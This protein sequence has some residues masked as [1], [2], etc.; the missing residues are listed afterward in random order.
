MEIDY[1]DG[2]VE[3]LAALYRKGWEME[4][5]AEAMELPLA[6][7]SQVVHLLGLGD[8]RYKGQYIPSKGSVSVA[9]PASTPCPTMSGR[10]GR[11]GKH[12]RK[13]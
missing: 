2:T 12:G 13:K 11:Y 6:Y 1:S 4:D 8:E 10:I 7:V 3:A 9:Y 5:I